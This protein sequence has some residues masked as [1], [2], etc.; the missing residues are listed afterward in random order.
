MDLQ[1]VLKNGANALGIELGDAQIELFW[2]YKDF[3]KEYNEKVNLTA[4]RD[5]E[6]I[7]VKH[8]L[9]CL[10]LVPHIAGGRVIDIGTGPGF[11]GL[12]LK[13][14]IPGLDLTLLDARAKKVKF[15][16]EAS[17][18]LELENVKC[19]HGRAEDVQKKVAAF[20]YAVSRAVGQLETLAG[21][22]LPFVKNGGRLIVMK[23]PN[24]AEELEKG[25][26]A[27]KKLGGEIKEVVTLTL[28]GT[29]MLRNLVI[30]EKKGR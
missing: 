19:L 3:L 15:L 16:K 11:P 27:I 4:I 18:L 1:N 25:A 9:D 5:D 6:G 29:D 7:V 26:A 23:G 2:K 28:P 8:F 22:C 24:Y 12:V 13:I 21:W 30:I 10:T 17:A 14:A 20:D